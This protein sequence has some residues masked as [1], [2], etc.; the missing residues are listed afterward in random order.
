MG[1]GQGMT[2]TKGKW[3]DWKAEAEKALK[4]KGI[5]CLNSLTYE[6]ITLKPLYVKEDTDFVIQTS[7]REDRKHNNWRVS[8]VLFADDP[9]TLCKRI[10]H[11][12]ARGQDSFYLKNFSFLE[13]KQEIAAAFQSID[14]EQDSIFFD[15]GE[16]FEFIPR[17]LQY[18]KESQ[19]VKAAKGTLG[20]DPYESLL[21]KGEAPIALGTQY[22]F[23]AD[24]I[25]WCQKNQSSVRTIL[26]KGN[27]YH[28]AGGHSVQ[29]LVY[30]FSHALDVINELIN[31]GLSITTIAKR[32]AFTFAIGSNFYMEIAKLRAAKQIWASLLHA[33][34]GDEVSPSMFL[35]AVTSSFNKSA[36]D[37]HVN[38]LRTTTEGFAAAVAGVDELTILPFDLFFAE[39]GSLGERIARNTQFILKEESLISRVVDPA[40]GAYY[41]EVLTNELAEK[42]WREIVK[43]DE[44]GGF[45]RLLTKGTPQ[46]E[47]KKTADTRLQDV[48]WQ[49]TK[50]IGI[51]AF[52]N[53]EDR[54]LAKRKEKKVEAE[55]PSAG[56]NPSFAEAWKILNESVST[57]SID[58]QE[59][60]PVQPL[61]IVRLAEHYEQLRFHSEAYE[62]YHGYKPTVTVM[63]FG[64][65][66]DYKPRLDFLTG[67]LASGGLQVDVV[68]S[69]SEITAIKGNIM[70]CCG[71]DEDY[72]CVDFSFI[73]EIKAVNKQA[74]F[75]IVGN[76]H[77]KKMEESGISG[78][79]T[80]NMNAYEYLVTL[81]QLIGVR[82]R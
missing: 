26:I 15:V 35:H 47:L 64:R 65:L 60:H 2:Q 11:A 75:F 19:N 22:D 70:I 28:E 77:D 13:N 38:L 6:G 73:N 34:G 39:E 37:I 32:L 25:K 49:K 80:A 31:R 59:L 54:V 67:L 45:L 46:K 57:H 20:F 58:K 44:N 69:E 42:A 52:A 36:F 43:I 14:W 24:S 71:K 3:I 74:T 27:L 17:F 81:H 9:S 51:N 40:A 50:I 23:L 29:E 61:T 78:S 1:D 18:L 63:V 76:G 4:G 10:K 82:E 56:S 7:K 30:T 16:K 21:I 48:N 41:I 5:E 12:K 72:E 68:S 53:L 55:N 8:Q 33:L 79:V 66:K 62:Q